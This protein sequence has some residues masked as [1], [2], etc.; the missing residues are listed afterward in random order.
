MAEKY[1]TTETQEQQVLGGIDVDIFKYDVRVFLISLRKRLPFLLLIP[2]AVGS[3]TIG[4]VLSMPKNWMATCTLFKSTA[5]EKKAGELSTLRK[6]LSIEAIKDMIRTKQNMR[7][8]ISN[9]KLSMSMQSL[10]GATGIT[11]AE[12]NRNMININASSVS[13]RLAADIAN[14]L[15]SVFLKTY[16]KMRNRTVQKRY[17]YFAH[18]KIGVMNTIKTLQAE[19][20]AYLKK[21]K[22]SAIALE[23]AK[24]FKL[25]A[26]LTT[27]VI[28]AEHKQHSLRI[29]IK[30]Y[31]EQIKRLD[32]EIVQSYEVTTL[33]DTEIVLKKN[34]LAVLRQRFTD[35]NPKV[36]KLVAE[37]AGLQKKMDAEKQKKRPASK[38]TYSKNWE[39]TNLE[40][41]IF[42]AKTELKG[43]TAALEKYALEKPI[44]KAKLDR[45]DRTATV[46]KEIKR[47]IDLAY[48]LLDKIDTGVTEMS[49]ALSSTVT[50]LRMF[51]K[52]EP[53]VYP[54]VNKRRK[55]VVLGF[56]LG[57][58]LSG[59][60][61]V[62]L[63]I[64]DLTIKSKFDIENVL[65]INGL[66]SLPKINEVRLKKFY[67]AIQVIFAR[68]FNA[69]I[70]LNRKNMLITFGDGE[71]GTGKTFFI[72][73]CID[74]FGP[75]D[76]R[77]LYIS[78]CNELASGL[79]KY[80]VND[81]IYNDQKIDEELAKENNDHL[82][83]LLDNYSYIVPITAV[84]IEEFISNFS[85]YDFIFWELFD[86]KKNEP[87]FATICSV[88]HSTVIMTKF[89][90]TKKIAALKC[91]KYLKE[92][93]VKNIGGIVNSVEK[94]YFANE[95]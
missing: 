32:P 92:H 86:F 77:I 12:K 48:E 38:T 45:L 28:V 84:Q 57:V 85:E 83:F 69:D 55:V 43:I 10:Y 87:L 73:K 63:E 30:E 68:I 31:A 44:I 81:F 16:E 33:D 13:A 7:D 8:V 82:Y 88:A 54:T 49:L 94:R 91:V 24:D 76:K 56:I 27:K 18:Q 46:Y 36:K 15:G 26:D 60:I 35:M 50:D 62:I 53:P 41:R 66:G 64:I 22:I 20:K 21:H 29:Q 78:S 59:V 5:E 37:I 39:I 9:L 70:A 65:H 6:P 4:Y 95:V 74:V 2:L 1:K 67:S 58:I 23:G 14:E 79:V 71:G 93:N 61:A 75:M 72:K 11:I 34:E 25:L 40:N 42:N 47:K 17:D 19:K 52:A 89:K 51:E 90:K 80:K 3:M